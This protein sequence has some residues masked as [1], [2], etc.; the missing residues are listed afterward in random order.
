MA[1]ID[2]I[3][4]Q[5]SAELALLPLESEELE[6]YRDVVNKVTTACSIISQQQKEFYAQ[7]W[8]EGI[9]KLISFME[10]QSALPERVTDSQIKIELEHTVHR[11]VVRLLSLLEKP[12]NPHDLDMC[13]ELIDDMRSL[14]G[15]EPLYEAFAQWI[16]RWNVPLSDLN[17]PTEKLCQLAPYLTSINLTDYED[18][19]NQMSVPV[20]L[21]GCM[22]AKRIEFFAN[23]LSARDFET[24]PESIEEI[25]IVSS[26]INKEVNLDFGRF[27]NLVNLGIQNSACHPNLVDCSRCGNL[28]SLVLKNLPHFKGTILLPK[29]TSLTNVSLS[30]MSELTEKINFEDCQKVHKLSLEHLFSYDQTIDLSHMSELE[31]LAIINC[32]KWS[33]GIILPKSCPLRTID[34]SEDRSLG[35]DLSAIHNYTSLERIDLTNCR[36]FGGGI[37]FSGLQ[38]LVLLRLRNCF[39]YVGLVDCSHAKEGVT[40]DVL[41]HKE[42]LTVRLPEHTTEY[43]YLT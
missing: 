33:K 26:V 32:P 18:I 23:D 43:T 8:V 27:P 21:S 7:E 34:L 31:C 2:S 42:G 4:S 25:K 15:S 37:D 16:S 38:N 19:A 9:G 22:R 20:F 10:K 28:S 6:K 1:S 40:I 11:L 3:M 17:W 29:N 39:S 30:L 41:G 24:I 13:S 35:G 12:Q 14:A 36:A 5:V